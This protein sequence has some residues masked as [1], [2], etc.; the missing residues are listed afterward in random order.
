[1][2]RYDDVG[3]AHLLHKYHL[4]Q[5]SNSKQLR[6]PIKRVSPVIVTAFVEMVAWVLP[7]FGDDRCE[8][9]RIMSDHVSPLFRVM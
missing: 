3:I 6:P 8:C 5:H 1:M 7:K 4:Y 2:G 9:V